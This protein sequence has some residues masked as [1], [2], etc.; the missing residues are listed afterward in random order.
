[1]RSAPLNYLVTFV[2]AGLLW[3]LL[4]LVLGNS[5]STSVALNVAT[6]EEFVRLYRIVLSV[7][8]LGGFALTAYW[9]F[10]G[11]RKNTVGNLQSVKRLW[12]VLLLTALALS[13]ALLVVLLV[14]F[15][16]E[17]FTGLQYVTFYAAISALTWLLFWG[18]TFF[19]SPRT[20]QYLPIGK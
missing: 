20:V 10:V 15:S 4:G 11:S 1:M 13:V 14:L 12:R 5:L 18:A 19:L 2:I 17:T 7:A 9:Y 3:A 6:V 8:A 16:D